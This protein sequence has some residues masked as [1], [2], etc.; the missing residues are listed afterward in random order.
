VSRGQSSPDGTLAREKFTARKAPFNPEP[1]MARVNELLT[2][3]GRSAW[4]VSEGAGLDHQALY[5]IRNGARPDM[6]ALI[7]SIQMN[8]FPWPGG[9][10]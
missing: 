8:S 3:S 2:E 6:S 10:R 1:L 5:R 4:A 7:G 9:L